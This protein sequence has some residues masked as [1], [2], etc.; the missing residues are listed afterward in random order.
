MLANAILV[1]AFI[2]LCEVYQI[3][4]CLCSTKFAPTVRCLEIAVCAP[5]GVVEAL[6]SVVFVLQGLMKLVEV[7]QEQVLY[8]LVNSD[9]ISAS[10]VCVL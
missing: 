4:T 5:Y 2:C 8:R 3:F 10:V 7:P 1:L 9:R 6:A